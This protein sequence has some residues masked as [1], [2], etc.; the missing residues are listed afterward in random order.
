M[1]R[2]LAVGCLTLA[3]MMTTAAVTA[4]QSN[5]FTIELNVGQRRLAGMPLHW[6]RSRV[7]LLAR[8]G[9]VWDFAP[10][11][12]R[13]YRK[14]S[15]SFQSLP[16]GVV[17]ARL[18]R[19]FGSRF[20][21][22]GTGHY[23]VVHPKGQGAKWAQRFEDLYR[24][25]VHYFTARG[26]RPQRPQFPLVA[27]VFPTRQQFVRYAA[28]SGSR[29][30]SGVLGYYSPMTNRVLLYDVTA[31]QPDEKSWHVNADTIIHEATH[32]TAFNTGLHRRLADTP[33][34]VAEGLATMFEAPGVWDSLKHRF[35]KDRLNRHRLATF[36]RYAKRRNSGTMLDIVTSDR[37]FRRNP[38]QAYAEA[39]A[40]TFFLV[41]TRP[42]QYSAYLAKT[43]ARPPLETYTA[44]ERL[45]DF[46]QFFGDRLP[47]LEAEMVRF[48]LGLE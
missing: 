4:A 1:H 32:Q 36:K 14:L 34:W 21:V 37:P 33:V 3:W 23:L 18:Q 12:A 5:Q 46:K 41:E 44:K 11:E 9:R 40:L 6:D 8:D 31:G 22:T 43:A 25:F 30:S 15:T 28:K 45:A 10:S 29:V 47:I 2:S 27:V 16:Q 13:D 39:W 24:S 19:E 26:F 35:R 17:R 38:A 48:T 7:Y 42:R 20:E